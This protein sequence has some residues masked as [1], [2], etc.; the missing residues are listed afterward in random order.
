MIFKKRNY[1]NFCFIVSIITVILFFAFSIIHSSNLNQNFNAEQLTESQLSLS[2]NEQKAFS[3]KM[4][5]I[6]EDEIKESE[7][8]L[9]NELKE[10]IDEQLSNLDL[11]DLEIFLSNL[12]EEQKEIFGALGILEKLQAII[13][14]EFGDDTSSVFEALIKITFDEILKLLPLMASIIAI[15]ILAGLLSDFRGNSQSVGDIIHF[16]CYGVIITIIAGAT[17]QMIALTTNTLNLI[18]TQME[19]VFPILLTLLTAMGGTVSV[20]IYQPAVV[21]LTAVV[22]QIFTHI[23]MPIFIFSLVFSIVSNLSNSVKLD[24]LSGFLNSMFKW[25]IG[26]VFT[27]FMGFL[28]IKGITAGSIDSI[29]F[30]TARYSLST[31]IPILGGYLSEGLNV[32]LAS[33]LL[34]KNAVGAS[35]LLLLFASIIIPLFQLILFMLCLKFTGAIL[36]PLSDNRISNFISSIS[37]SFLM[38][39]VM[40]IGVA[41]MYVI[42]VGIIMCTSVSF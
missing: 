21:L 16:V 4:Q 2:Q 42:F 19:I 29:S 32:I 8:D 11:A 17:L 30:K 3:N 26:I 36:Q 9:E 24:K 28:A 33:C 39:I 13:S 18:V 12:S 41:F 15:A 10:N 37:K 6:E 40:I 27:I 5:N 38:P 31:Y 23:L 25:I 35:G 22:A 20:A 1:I 7:D 34:I 14:G